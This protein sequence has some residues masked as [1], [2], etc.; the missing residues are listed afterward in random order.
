MMTFDRKRIFCRRVARFEKPKAD[1]KRVAKNTIVLY[2]RMLAVMAIGL[3]TGRVTFNALGVTDYGL[4]SIA[5]GVIGMITFMMGSLSGASS[6]FIVVEMG[7][8]SIGT[9]KRV[10]STIFIVHLGLACIFVI[11]LETIG[12]AFLETKL[13]IDPSRI[14]AVKWTYHCAVF[15][16]FLGITQVPYGAVINAHERMSAFAWMTIYDVVVKLGIAFAIKYYGG[17]KLILL[18]TLG[19]VSSVTTMMIYRIYCIRNFTEARFRRVFDTSLVKPIFSFAGIHIFTQTIIMLKSQ[20]VLMI[21]Q[22]YFGPALVAA[23][24]IGAV[25][26]THIQGFIGNFKAAANPQI[27][28]LFSAGRFVESKRMLTETL[29]FSV[30]LLLLLGVPAWFYSDEALTIWL[31]P[32]RPELSPIIAK[33]ILAGAFFSLFDSSLYT[34]LHAA[35]RIKENMYFNVIGGILTFGLV[36]YL[37]R[38][39]H[40]PLASVG[41]A[42]GYFILLGCV[43]KPILLHW[44]AD[45]TLRDFRRIFIPSFEALAICA[46]IGFALHSIMPTGLFWA[47]PSCAVIGV[48]N[49]VAIYFLVA[50]DSMQQQFCRALAKVPRYGIKA[51]RLLSTGN[52]LVYPLRSVLQRIAG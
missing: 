13:N 37:V 51:V 42:A 31:G 28:K 29:L 1:P 12:L 32:G 47:I 33:I 46:S 43:F 38:W 35:G 41:V 15:T 36:F 8:G 27:I 26:N 20:G 5:G 3:F 19:A 24:S 6:R 17:D 16:T 50:P 10:F 18:A 49:A 9:L 7:R 25:L 30:F 11:L 44:I 34:V 23:I 14:F 2:V 40:A 4:Q 45:Y 39:Q 21:N 52:K 48:L 22:R